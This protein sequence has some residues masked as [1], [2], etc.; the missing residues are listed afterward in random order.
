MEF[1]SR[2]QYGRR[3]TSSFDF[4]RLLFFVDLIVF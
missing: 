2:R 1:E 3:R 4:D